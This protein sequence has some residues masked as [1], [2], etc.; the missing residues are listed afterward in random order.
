MI[1]RAPARRAAGPFPNGPAL[2]RR[3]IGQNR[4]NLLTTS[5]LPCLDQFGLSLKI[6]EAELGAAPPPTVVTIRNPAPLDRSSP[7]AQAVKIA[8]VLAGLMHLVLAAILLG[9]PSSSPTLDSFDIPG[10]DATTPPAAALPASALA[11]DRATSMPT[12][13]ASPAL[14]PL[15]TRPTPERIA[16]KRTTEPV[17]AR[18]RRPAHTPSPAY[19]RTTTS[20]AQRPTGRPATTPHRATRP[21]TATADDPPATTSKRIPPGRTRTPPGQASR[22]APPGQPE[23]PSDQA[24]DKTQGPKDHPPG[25]GG[26]YDSPN[27]AQRERVLSEHPAELSAAA[28]S[29]RCGRGCR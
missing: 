16:P 10:S 4:V 17:P 18:T 26:Q 19:T 21:V 29:P 11:R 22:Q 7:T 23:R 9:I 5:H 28:P 14:S 6:P 24:V 3:P 25:N 27:N 1:Q 13:R 8:T 2:R 12:A 15:S 20:P